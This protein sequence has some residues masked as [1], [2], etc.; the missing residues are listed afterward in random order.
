MT[1]RMSA[2]ESWNAFISVSIAAGSLGSVDAPGR[3]LL[4]VGDEEVVEVAADEAAPS[5]LLRNDVDD[6][7][8]VEVAGLAEER[9]LAVVVV[10]RVVDEAGVVVA[11]RVER[12]A[13]LERPAGERPRCTRGRPVSV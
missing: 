3:H 8:A 10:G 6:V 7:L 4:L 12:R 5:L 9:L 1:E 2:S 13:W 11:V